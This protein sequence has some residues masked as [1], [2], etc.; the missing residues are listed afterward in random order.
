MHLL[1]LCAR[2]LGLLR[3]HD[4]LANARNESLLVLILLVAACFFFL[5]KSQLLCLLIF[6]LSLGD[7]SKMPDVILHRLGI[8]DP[9]Q[10]HEL[11]DAVDVALN[12]DQ[13]QSRVN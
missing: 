8:C 5:Y 4:R 10:L 3:A 9:R 1:D 7:A 12:L 2:N 11:E 6:L 13:L